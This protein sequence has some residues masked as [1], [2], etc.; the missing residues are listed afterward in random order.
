MG[1][2]FIS[3]PEHY[4]ETKASSLD[5][6]KRFFLFN[7]SLGQPSEPGEM[8]DDETIPAKFEAY[9]LSRFLESN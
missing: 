6:E 1:R 4:L 5:D 2:A 9:I 7:H 3:D 8:S